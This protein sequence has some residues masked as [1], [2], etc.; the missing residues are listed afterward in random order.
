[1]KVCLVQSGD[2]AVS[3]KK[4]INK[5]LVKQESTCHATWVSGQPWAERRPGGSGFSS[6]VWRTTTASIWGWQTEGCFKYLQSVT[7]T[8][9]LFFLFAGQ[10][11]KTRSKCVG[12]ARVRNFPAVSVFARFCCEH[13]FFFFLLSQYLKENKNQTNCKKDTKQR[14]VISSGPNAYTG[15]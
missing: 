7:T 13:F 9:L 15:C 5:D 11:H 6:S 4:K 2:L 8:L 12:N 1:M 10:T 3:K 14:R